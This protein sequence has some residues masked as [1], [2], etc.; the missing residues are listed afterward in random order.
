MVQAITFLAKSMSLV[1][2]RIAHNNNNN[3]NNNNSNLMRDPK[4]NNI[5]T[6]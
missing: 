3:N 2:A 5:V 1:F 4:D 6:D